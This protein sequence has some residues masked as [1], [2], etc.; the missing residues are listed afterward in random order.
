LAEFLSSVR[1][2]EIVIAFTLVEA[3][4]LVAYHRRTG[5]GV[6]P[7]EFGANLVSGLCLMLAL[8]CALAGGWW[9]WTALFLSASGLVHGADLWRRWR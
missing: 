8:R 3:V 7:V 4:A 2:I 1:L 6:A 9:L 5:K